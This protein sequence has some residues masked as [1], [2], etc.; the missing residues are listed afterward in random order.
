MFTSVS[1]QI[2][3]L[4]HPIHCKPRIKIKK[5][6]HKFCTLSDDTKKYYQN[7]LGSEYKI[8]E[9]NGKRGSDM[10]AFLVVDSQNNKYVLKIAFSAASLQRHMQGYKTFKQ[11]FPDYNGPFFIPKLIKYG[12]DFM[13]MEYAG[14]PI[15][16]KTISENPQFFKELAQTLVCLHKKS[17]SHIDII[18]LIFGFSR[19]F[20]HY[21][22]GLSIKNE[23]LK[24]FIYFVNLFDECGT[25]DEFS[26]VS[27]GDM[28]FNNILFNPETK[29]FAL[30]DFGAI[31]NNMVIYEAIPTFKSNSSI[32][33]K[34]IKYY[35]EY[36]D[37][38]L[39]FLKMQIYNKLLFYKNNSR[40]M[41]EVR[42]LY[43]K[44]KT[45]SL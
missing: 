39:N 5:Q 32:A 9:T 13:L 18:D 14:E 3:S 23:K 22:K 19:D 34:I 43:E 15:S 37:F 1:N 16:K 12:D 10:A 27:Y 20:I 40:L 2:F 8:V 42:K 25:G 36:S 21:L 17:R 6:S 41:G 33:K 30:V 11:Y 29:R 44:Y 4:P 31:G 38:K 28:R 45:A 26:V 35:N 7:I 24:R